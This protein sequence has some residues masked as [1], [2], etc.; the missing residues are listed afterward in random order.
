MNESSG[1]VSDS[2]HAQIVRE[3]VREA[4]RSTVPYRFDSQP[5]DA[6]SVAA[7]A[8][9]REPDATQT[10]APDPAVVDTESDPSYRDRVQHPVMVM[11]D[12]L[13]EGQRESLRKSRLSLWQEQR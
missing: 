2:P 4:M 6:S 13:N 8:P 1:Y 7:R 11:V 3:S 9:E 5:S 12:L 10:V